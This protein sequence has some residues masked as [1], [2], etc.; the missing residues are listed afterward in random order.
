MRHDGPM[1]HVGEGDRETK[2]EGMEQ[3]DFTAAGDA[4]RAQIR[5]GFNQR[6]CGAFAVH[7][8]QNAQ[9]M[10]TERAVHLQCV[11]KRTTKD[12]G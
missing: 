8:V 5:D 7:F 6:R 12:V 11:S 9:K 4:N 10:G 3:S 1:A 2:L